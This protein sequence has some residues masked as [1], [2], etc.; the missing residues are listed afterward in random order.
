MTNTGKIVLGLGA[1]AAIVGIVAI[2]SSKSSDSSDCGELIVD[3]A[4]LQRLADAEDS[5]EAQMP[6]QFVGRDPTTLTAEEVVAW[7]LGVAWPKCDFAAP[8]AEA[9]I[10]SADGS[11]NVKWSDLRAGLHGLMLT[12]PQWMNVMKRAFGLPTLESAGAPVS[13]FDQ[14]IASMRTV[15]R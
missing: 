5:A 3:A 11:V 14:A 6:A 2:A 8:N 9:T 13:S 4:A 7:M 10:V 15:L 12:D 1:L